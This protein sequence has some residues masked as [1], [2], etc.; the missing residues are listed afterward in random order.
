MQGG[1]IEAVAF[2]PFSLFVALQAEN[3]EG[4]GYIGIGFFA[5]QKT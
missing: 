4:F 3:R 1:S 5:N 2:C